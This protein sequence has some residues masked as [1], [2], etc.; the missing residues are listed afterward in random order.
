M[1]PRVPR[2]R[3]CTNEQ[4]DCGKDLS[5]EKCMKCHWNRNAI[6]IDK[7]DISVGNLK[8]IEGDDGLCRLRRVNKKAGVV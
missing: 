7:I 2:E 6:E 4:T 3:G 8:L 5:L 1:I